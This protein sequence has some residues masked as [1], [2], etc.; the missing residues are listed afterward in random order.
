MNRARDYAYEIADTVNN[1]VRIQIRIEGME[2]AQ[3]VYGDAED[4]E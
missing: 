2:K 1:A 3:Y 4:V